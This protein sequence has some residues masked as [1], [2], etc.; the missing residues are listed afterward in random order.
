M[1]P[2]TAAAVRRLSARDRARLAARLDE[3]R[4]IDRLI[5]EPGSLAEAPMK[6]GC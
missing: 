3:L 1:S 2:R 6:R 4:R 5:R